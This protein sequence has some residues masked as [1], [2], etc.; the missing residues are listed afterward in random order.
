MEYNITLHTYKTE[1]I[2]SL[3]NEILRSWE[4][5][6]DEDNFEESLTEMVDKFFIDHSPKETAKIMISLTY[7]NYVEFVH[8]E[9]DEFVEVLA[10]YIMMNFNEIMN[11]VRSEVR[12][13]ATRI[14]V[15]N[16]IHH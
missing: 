5:L 1:A 10:K 8:F 3:A 4:F 15:N 6:I 11:K 14:F 12:Y 2:K 7:K 13:I 9:E 16:S